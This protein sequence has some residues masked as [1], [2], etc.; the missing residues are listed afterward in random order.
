MGTGELAQLGLC[1]AG[2]TEHRQLFPTAVFPSKRIWERSPQGKTSRAPRQGSWREGHL[3]LW[4]DSLT[5][6]ALGMWG[7]GLQQA[8][9]DRNK[10]TKKV[11]LVAL[12]Y[13]I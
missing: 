2:A 10:Q 4:Q 5:T 13:F 8:S 9:Q 7:P 11:F 3:L 6:T 1:T 12:Q